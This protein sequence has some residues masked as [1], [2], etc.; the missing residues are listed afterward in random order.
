[1]ETRNGCVSVLCQCWEMNLIGFTSWEEDERDNR[2]SLG[3]H[4]NNYWET[5]QCLDLGQLNEA[6]VTLIH[7]CDL[8]TSS[9]DWQ[10]GTTQQLCSHRAHTLTSTNHNHWKLIET[11]YHWL[12]ATQC[13]SGDQKSLG[14][15]ETPVSWTWTLLLQVLRSQDTVHIV[16]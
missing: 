3:N 9:W 4:N 7:T 11:N 15:W 12:S 2:F 14:R 13:Y 5:G 10:C 6:G 1:M 16:I 8:S